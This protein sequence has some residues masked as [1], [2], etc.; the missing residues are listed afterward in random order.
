MLQQTSNT[1]TKTLNKLGEEFSDGILSTW[2]NKIEFLSEENGKLILSTTSKSVR[3]WV[4]DN[5]F[6][7]LR[8]IVNIINNDVKS[9]E[10]ILVDNH[11]KKISNIKNEFEVLSI[12]NTNYTLDNFVEGKSNEFAYLASKIVAENCRSKD[13]PQISY[14]YSDVGMGKTHLLQAIYNRVKNNND[15]TRAIYLSADKFMYL[16][17]NSV[18]ENNV[19]SFRKAVRQ[20]DIFLMDDIQFIFGKKS[21]QAEVMSLINDLISENKKVIISGE[22]K[23][24]DFN[25]IDER[26]KSRLGSGLLLKIESPDNSLKQQIV[27]KKMKGFGLMLEDDMVTQIAKS[28][29]SNIRE[30]EGILN[31]AA[32]RFNLLNIDVTIDEIKSII[33]DYNASQE[34]IISQITVKHIQDAVLKSCLI[35]KSDLNSESRVSAIVFARQMFTYLAK[36]YTNCSLDQI[37]SFIGGK[38]HSTV[39]YYIKTFE[40]K[41]SENSSMNNLY[42]SCLKLLEKS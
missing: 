37:G 35:T 8:E 16:Y 6:H 24:S 21:T 28:S 23:P 31:Q 20:C 2:F 12:V 25:N 1:W 14:L 9:I 19:V 39:L 5:Y 10:I 41:L 33:K 17:M 3:E 7:K 38:K 22:K 34:V 13:I 15:G 18:K 27:K 36:R 4:L 30:I 42:N 29:K 32:T 40:K 11:H 26:I